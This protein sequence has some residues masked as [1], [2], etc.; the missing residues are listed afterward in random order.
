MHYLFDVP[1]DYVYGIVP[2]EIMQHKIG[3]LIQKKAGT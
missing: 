1:M 3:R 2:Y